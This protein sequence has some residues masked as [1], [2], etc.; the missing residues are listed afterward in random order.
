MCGI[1][2]FY[3]AEAADKDVMSNIL[4]AMSNTLV[5]RG[6]DSAGMWIDGDSGIYFAH[7]R[8]SIQDLSPLGNQPMLSQSGRFVIIFNGEIY[9]FLELRKKL[10]ME[11]CSFKGGSDTEVMLAAIEAWGLGRALANFTGMFAFVLWDRR[12]KQLILARD[13]L[14]EKPLYYGWQGNTFLFGSELKALRPHY[15]WNNIINRDAV[16]LLLRHN[17]IPAP[18]SIFEGIFKLLPGTFM[19]LDTSTRRYRTERFWSLAEIF[20][21][22][23][24]ASLDLPADDIVSLL[25]YK[26]LGIIKRQMIADVPVGAFLSG[27][28]DS[29]TVVA[30]MQAQ[31]ATPVKTFTIGFNEDEF[32]EAKYAKAIA[33]HLGTEHTE[34]YLTPKNVLDVIPKINMIYDEP[35]ADSSQLPTF[36]I[37]KL[38][39]EQVTVSLSGDG[40]DELF[41]GYPSYFKT[42]ASWKW[43]SRYPLSVRR[44]LAGAIRRLPTKVVNQLLYWPLRYFSN[45]SPHLAGMRLQRKSSTWQYN[46]LQEFYRQSISYWT[47][48]AVVRG[49][50]D[51]DYAMNSPATDFTGWDDYKLMQYLDAACYLPDDILTK[52]DRAAMANSLETRIPFLDHEFVEL[53]A[54]IP[55]DVNLRHPLGKWPLREILKRYVPTELTERPKKGFAVPLAQWLRNELKEWAGDLLSQQALSNTGMFDGRLVQNTWNNHINNLADN[56]F[57]LWGLIIYQSWNECWKSTA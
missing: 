38:T 7:R 46:S 14:G 48:T 39:R 56:S 11:G 12:V 42:H 28:I 4:E 54:K 2:G 34:L 53:A 49:C 6:P 47:D 22:G 23:Q 24:E 52:V 5:H 20:S 33:K 36:L 55:T 40:G 43:I 26:L 35:F 21:K 13:R 37:S 41:C 3:Q 27:G 25:E 17:Y 57:H 16:G 19:T 18:W 29:S 10:E 30:L 51:I 32:N 15:S 50:R 9:N 44:T 8:L 31:R 45:R 1:T